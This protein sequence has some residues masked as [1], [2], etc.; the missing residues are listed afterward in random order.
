MRNKINKKKIIIIVFICLLVFSV[1]YS[2]ILYSGIEFY[3][4]NAGIIPETEKIKYDFY[5]PDFNANIMNDKDYLDKIRE[6]KYTENGVTYI[7]SSDEYSNHGG[8]LVF[9]GKY[10]EHVIN[11]ENDEINKLF[12]QSYLDKNGL[13]GKFP[14]QRIY[15]IQIE[16]KSTHYFEDGEYA[17]NVRY[18]FDV[19]YKIMKND[20]MFDDG[21]PSEASKTRIYEI[22]EYEGKYLINSISEY[23]IKAN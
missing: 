15:D 19:S 9:L 4:P 8:A 10:F 5:S 1:V 23:M 18:L 21:I 14:M 11:G 2:V 7:L 22:L 6:I 16:K 13:F 17:G 20:G 12:T 3:N